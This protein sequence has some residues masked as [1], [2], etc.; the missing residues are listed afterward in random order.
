MGVGK[1]LICLSLILATLNQ[2]CLPP[3]NAVNPSRVTTT[4]REQT[5]PFDTDEKLRRIASI[6]SYHTS[7]SFPSLADIC[8][9]ILA[10]HEPASAQS[11][12]LSPQLRAA[13]EGRRTLYYD[14]PLPDDQ[15]KCGRGAK[16]KPKSEAVQRIYLA[17]TTLLVCPAILVKQWLKEIRDHLEDG[18]LKVLEVASEQIPPIETLMQYDVSGPTSPGK[19]PRNTS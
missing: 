18:S 1:S 13:I 5:Y 8:V 3:P 4:H 12:E 6:P 10:V 16:A 7:L 15:H 11:A 19:Q 9:D 2:P 14:M 17:N